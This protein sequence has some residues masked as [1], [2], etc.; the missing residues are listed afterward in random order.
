MKLTSL[1]R[2]DG[3]NMRSSGDERKWGVFTARRH[4][5][6]GCIAHTCTGNYTCSVEKIREQTL[7]IIGLDR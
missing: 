6:R 5:K 4:F 2:L 1:S 3:V 7:A